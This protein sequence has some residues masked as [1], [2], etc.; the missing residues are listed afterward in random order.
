LPKAVQDGG[1]I[2]K[3]FSQDGERTDFYESPCASPFNKELSK[4]TFFSQI[5]LTGQ[6]TVPLTSSALAKNALEKDSLLVQNKMSISS[7]CTEC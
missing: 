5:H 3:V 7:Q 6:W 1:G 2:F 4:K